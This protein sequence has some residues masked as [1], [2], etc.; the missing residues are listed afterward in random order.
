VWGDS[1]NW[2]TNAVWGDTSGA[3]A[4]NAVWGDTNGVG[5]K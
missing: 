3:T 5:E 1:G 4:S 2:G